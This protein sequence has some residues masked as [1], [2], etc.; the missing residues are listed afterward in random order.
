MSETREFNHFT[1]VD[2]LANYLVKEKDIIIS[3]SEAELILNYLDGHDYGI[4]VDQNNN[5]IM[6]DIAEDHGEVFEYSFNDVVDKVSE[7]NDDLLYR[8]QKKYNEGDLD[9]N[10]T[11]ICKERL[12]LYRSDNKSL[13][14]L[15]DRL[16]YDRKVKE[17]V[18]NFKE[19]NKMDSSKNNELS[20]KS[21]GLINNIFQRH[22]SVSFVRLQK[23]IQR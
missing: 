22:K 6:K 2:E 1:E 15:S 17:F 12:A 5:F 18:N 4:G 20:K 19:Q 13:E 23:K 7:W 8:E 14:M 3:T 11:V 21:M 9:F 16:D 10:E